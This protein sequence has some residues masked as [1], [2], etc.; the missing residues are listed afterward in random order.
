MADKID[1]HAIEHRSYGPVPLVDVRL[2]L[3]E[4]IGVVNELVEDLNTL[5][6]RV[7]GLATRMRQA[8]QTLKDNERN[9]QAGVSMIDECKRDKQ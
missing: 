5:T 6:G 9:Q 7:D 2:K 3:L 4:T 8:A 1:K